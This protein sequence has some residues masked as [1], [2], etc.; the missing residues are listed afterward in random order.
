[1]RFPRFGLKPARQKESKTDREQT[2]MGYIPP[3]LR[4][5]GAGAAAGAPRSTTSGET[6]A[7]A[8]P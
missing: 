5:K 1:M 3:H 2:S 6:Y 7:F 8:Q 4:E